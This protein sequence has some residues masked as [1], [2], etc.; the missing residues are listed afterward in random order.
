MENK[1]KW[2]SCRLAVHGD[3]GRVR[4]VFFN[5]KSK[6]RVCA[7]NTVAENFCERPE[8]RDLKLFCVAGGVWDTNGHGKVNLKV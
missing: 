7:E 5:I 1:T 3:S 4:Y 6:M 8:F 2:H